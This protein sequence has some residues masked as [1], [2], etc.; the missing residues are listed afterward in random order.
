MDAIKG[1]LDLLANLAAMKALRDYDGR[2]MKCRPLSVLK[3]DPQIAQ[4]TEAAHR[5]PH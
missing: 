1:A 2:K 4:I 5:A 3:V